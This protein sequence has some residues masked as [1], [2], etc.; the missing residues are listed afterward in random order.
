V[1]KS[2][3]AE[4]IAVGTIVY[5]GR[6]LRHRWPSK[7]AYVVALLV[8]QGFVTEKQLDVLYPKHAPM[9]TWVDWL[10]GKASKSCAPEGRP[11]EVFLGSVESQ[12]AFALRGGAGALPWVNDSIEFE[13]A[14]ALAPKTKKVTEGK[15]KAEPVKATATKVS[16]K[17]ETKPA[18]KLDEDDDDEYDDDEEDDDLD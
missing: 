18:A 11:G 9:G 6:T 1:A 2:V 17:K 8:H 5:K 3:K 16:P 13:E 4:A 14:L 15:V 12:K 7:Q 10:N